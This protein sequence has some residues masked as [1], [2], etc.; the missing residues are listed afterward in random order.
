MVG[1]VEDEAITR[2]L[3]EYKKAPSA[4]RAKAG[5]EAVEAANVKRREMFLGSN[6]FKYTTEGWDVRIPQEGIEIGGVFGG[7]PSLTAKAKRGELAEREAVER[8]ISETQAETGALHPAIGQNAWAGAQFLGGELP[9]ELTYLTDIQMTKGKGY[10]LDPQSILDAAATDYDGQQLIGYGNSYALMRLAAFATD[11]KAY[12]Q[13]LQLPEVQQYLGD[14]KAEGLECDKA[15]RDQV[16]ADLGGLAEVLRPHMVKVHKGGTPTDPRPAELLDEEGKVL[17]RRAAAAASAGLPVGGDI[18][19]NATSY[20]DDP[21]GVEHGIENAPVEMLPMIG[22]NAIARGDGMTA[23]LALQRHSQEAL[24]RL[25]TGGEIVENIPRSAGHMALGLLN[26]TGIP[27]FSQSVA[28]HIA[29]A[30]QESETFRG[31]WNALAP[32][33]FEVERVE[34]ATGYDV[35]ARFHEDLVRGAEEALESLKQWPR[36]FQWLAH[37]T[38]GGVVPMDMRKAREVQALYEREPVMMG[39]DVLMV[40]QPTMKLAGGLRGLYAHRMT[41]LGGAFRIGLAEGGALYKRMVTIDGMLGRLARGVRKA[42]DKRAAKTMENFQEAIRKG[43]PK[44]IDR[45]RRTMSK[46]DEGTLAELAEGVVGELKDVREM[47]KKDA[48]GAAQEVG[49]LTKAEILD[50]LIDHVQVVKELDQGYGNAVRALGHLAESVAGGRWTKRLMNMANRNLSRPSEFVTEATRALADTLKGK[51]P[52]EIRGHLAHVEKTRHLLDDFGVQG[53]DSTRT[54]IMMAANEGDVGALAQLTVGQD[55]APA[56]LAELTRFRHELAWTPDKA[57]AEAVNAAAKGGEAAGQT[58]FDLVRRDIRTAIEEGTIQAPMFENVPAAVDAAALDIALEAVGHKGPRP[59]A[60]EF[61]RIYDGIEASPIMKGLTEKSK[62]QVALYIMGRLTPRLQRNKAFKGA[63]IKYKNS[64]TGKISEVPAATIV[65]RFEDVVTDIGALCYE[66]GLAAVDAGLIDI[67]ALRAHGLEYVHNVVNQWGMKNVKGKAKQLLREAKAAEDPHSVAMLDDLVQQL[68]NKR[69]KMPAREQ[70]WARLAMEG[71]E[72]IAAV[73]GSEGPAAL[74][75]RMILE[76]FKYGADSVDPMMAGAVGRDVHRY[77]RKGGPMAMEETYRQIFHVRTL[78]KTIQHMDAWADDVAA[79]VRD[80]THSP[81][82][83]ETTA[84][85]LQD[86]FGIDGAK[87]PGDPAARTVQIARILDEAK[88]VSAGALPNELL[89]HLKKRGWRPA[90]QAFRE[91]APAKARMLAKYGKDI[92]IH[93]DQVAFWK[94]LERAKRQPKTK[95]QKLQRWLVKQ[96]KQRKIVFETAPWVRDEISNR[97]VVGPTG[98]LMPWSPAWTLASKVIQ[99]KNVF[100]E[101][102]RQMGLIESGLEMEIGAGVTD[103]AFGTRNRLLRA[104]DDHHHGNPMEVSGLIANAVDIR[105]RAAKTMLGTLEETAGLVAMP[106]ETRLG[107]WL[108]YERNLVDGRARTAQAT[109]DIM[110]GVLDEALTDPATAAKL[111]AL[112]KQIKIKAK[113]PHEA[114][115]DAWMGAIHSYATKGAGKAGRRARKAARV[116][117][118]EKGIFKRDITET[119]RVARQAKGEAIGSRLTSVF[120]EILDMLPED[121]L[122]AAV[123][124]ARKQFVDYSDTPAWVDFLSRKVYGVPFIKYSAQM[125][126]RLTS[127]FLRNPVLSEGMFHMSNAANTIAY[128]I[129]GGEGAWLDA[130]QEHQDPWQT[131]LPMFPGVPWA[132]SVEEIGTIQE[133][134]GID[135]TWITPFGGGLGGLNPIY[136]PAAQSVIPL[137]QMLAGKDPRSAYPLRWESVGKTRMAPE[138]AGASMVTRGAP[139]SQKLVELAGQLTKPWLH[140]FVPPGIVPGPEPTGTTVSSTWQPAI[141][142]LFGIASPNKLR[143][144]PALMMLRALGIKTLP[145]GERSTTARRAQKRAYTEEKAAATKGMGQRVRRRNYFDAARDASGEEARSEISAVRSQVGTEGLKRRQGLATDP[146]RDAHYLAERAGLAEA[147]CDATNKRLK[148]VGEAFADNMLR[149]LS[150]P[151][152]A[153][154]FFQIAP[155]QQRAFFLAIK[156]GVAERRGINARRILRGE[157]SLGTE[158]EIAPAQEVLGIPV[159]EKGPDPAALRDEPVMPS[160]LQYAGKDYVMEYVP[161]EPGGTSEAQRYGKAVRKYREKKKARR[162]ALETSPERYVGFPEEREPDVLLSPEEQAKEYGEKR[163][164]FVKEA[165]A[166]AAAIRRILR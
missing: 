135:T 116:A 115:V 47:L 101:R 154:M 123:E 9:E 82:V 99:T 30:S 23:K 8:G 29:A 153:Q 86:R 112:G 77:L 102:L 21:E 74:K 39:L 71:P 119:G 22:D 161:G 92:L 35:E 52:G 54:A 49:G 97:W 143:G 34:G 118:R 31:I 110:K 147:Q 44:A 40:T 4:Q 111:D 87:L 105:N 113:L 89:G 59:G 139:T 145:F 85:F 17:S 70:E 83:G 11:R 142:S 114:P 93:P 27:I 158:W 156:H 107:Q 125:I 3:R 57:F 149:Q 63:T 13:M 24:P 55:L 155:T 25:L 140:G 94:V 7:A 75:Q 160:Y 6:P 108:V 84:K 124:K 150:Q 138:P 79:V 120:D 16:N 134:G 5:K 103:I 117:E 162:G 152:D 28:A 133:T 148:E 67:K 69:S 144:P 95:P 81:V 91:I 2:A 48:A 127:H 41:G 141:E 137:A 60:N 18:F 136:S 80:I 50:K 51:M 121:R 157:E 32:Q 15:V 73:Y 76:S 26:L 131:L 37:K 58:A 46:W 106:G 122:A 10:G 100:F 43:D 42:M 163:K 104:L 78:A 14:H 65:D 36:N 12:Y 98:G 64:S 130:Y 62:R 56:Q 166:E 151:M 53:A 132:T 129:M 128:N 19:Q 61:V 1:P 96:L 90:S 72:F 20:L 45:A 66:T 88:A 109:L 38:T 165:E 68:K 159:S 126:P 33:A 146:E 164:R